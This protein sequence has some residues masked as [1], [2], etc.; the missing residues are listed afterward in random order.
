MQFEWDPHKALINLE[1][2]GIDFEDAIYIFAGPT[3][4]Y[5][6]TRKDYGET[7]VIALGTLDGRVLVVVYTDR[8]DIRRII[9]ARKAND[10]E[11]RTYHAALARRSPPDG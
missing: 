5:P 8:A 11:Q 3:L 10:H 2:H 6:D 4:E 9:S 1:K 7:R